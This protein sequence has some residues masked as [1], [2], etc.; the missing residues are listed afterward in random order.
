MTGGRKG[1]HTMSMLHFLIEE[2][3]AEREDLPT[4]VKLSE[5]LAADN[6]T[7]PP[8]MPAV[9]RETASLQQGRRQDHTRS[10]H[11]STEV[12]ATPAEP[13]RRAARS[14]LDFVI[15]PAVCEGE[16][17][18]T[19]ASFPML[20]ILADQL[21]QEAEE[22][23]AAA[24]GVA[25]SAKKAQEEGPATSVG[26]AP[27]RVAIGEAEGEGGET[28]NA[29]AAAA[30]V[31]AIPIPI[32]PDAKDW[33]VTYTVAATPPPLPP[34]DHVSTDAAPADTHVP[35]E[36]PSPSG[37]AP[38]AA[39]EGPQPVGPDGANE[40]QRRD[41]VIKPGRPRKLPKHPASA[42]VGDQG[43][44]ARGRTPTP[45]AV[46]IAGRAP[47]SVVLALRERRM[48][49]GEDP[50]SAVALHSRVRRS[51]FIERYMRNLHARVGGAA[52]EPLSANTSTAPSTRQESVE[53]PLASPIRHQRGRS[54][55]PRAASKHDPGMGPSSYKEVVAHLAQEP[56]RSL[57]EDQRVLMAAQQTR[58]QPLASQAPRD[59]Q[60]LSRY[61]FDQ[62]LHQYKQLPPVRHARRPISAAVA[63]S[64]SKPSSSTALGPPAT[65]QRY[66]GGDGPDLTIVGS[67]L[68][69]PS[70]SAPRAAGK[71][72]N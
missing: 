53:V 34:P 7:P 1:G 27:S 60:G 14:M 51:A 12:D 2:G 36:A 49:M 21:A 67:R 10:V 41:V 66:R 69:I 52:A 42:L 59:G 72:L 55:S 40:K 50:S 62:R 43:G 31:M 28:S 30:P 29:A 5:M 45:P 19:A 17:G 9:P 63:L 4:L 22:R 57:E 48:S 23:E 39:A 44:P 15:S 65:P 68:S 54:R 25:E 71:F 6:A 33:G 32:V 56:Q 37:S 70:V 26:S 35:G 58:V 18:I 11:W 16:E 13:A 20:S 46:A 8:P 24:A 61:A 38:T 47:R 64:P 3:G